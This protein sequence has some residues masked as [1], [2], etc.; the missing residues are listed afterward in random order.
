[1]VLSH[2]SDF[3]GLEDSALSSFNGS[4]AL[5]RILSAD[6]LFLVTL[7]YVGSIYGLVHLIAWDGPFATLTQ[8]WMWRVSCFIIAAPAVMV[9]SSY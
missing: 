2:I 9:P 3:K 1:M 8:L 5:T 6:I 7:L 4:T